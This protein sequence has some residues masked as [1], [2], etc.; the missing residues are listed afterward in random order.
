MQRIKFILVT[1]SSIILLLIGINPIQGQSQTPKIGFAL[2]GGGAKGLAHI[3]VLKVFEEA[4]IYPDVITG[5]SMGSVVGGL[6]AIGYSA[7]ELDSIATSLNWADYF[8][9]T[10]DRSFRTIEDKDEV[11]R[12]VFS[13]P[14][15]GK[16]VQ[17]PRGF[18]DGQKLSILLSNLTQHVHGCPNFDDFETPFRCVGGDLETGE[19]IVFDSGFLPDAIRGSIGIPSVFEPVEI[20]E[21]LVVDGMIIRNLPVQDAFDLGA[22]IVIAVDV[23]SGLYKREQLSSILTVLDQTSSYRIVQSNLQQLELADIVVKPDMSKY[24]ALDFEKTD[25][26]IWEGEKAARHALPEIQK[27]LGNR[28]QN[29]L[30]RKGGIINRLPKKVDLS[31]IEVIGLVGKDERTFLNILQLGEGKSYTPERITE[32]IERVAA[33]GFYNKMSYRLVQEQDSFLLRIRSDKTDNAAIKLGANYHSN[34]NAA[35]LLNATYRNAIL[36]GSKFSLDIRVSE[37]PMLRANYLYYTKSRPNVGVK[38]GGIFNYYPG[39]LYFRN[40]LVGEYNFNMMQVR[41]DFFS[42][43]GLNTSLGF[44]ISAQ[45]H[46][47]SNR[48]ILL[49]DIV[50]PRKNQFITHFNFEFDNLNRKYFPTEGSRLHLSGNLVIEGELLATTNLE[51]RSST[52]GNMYH[53]LSYRKIFPLNSKLSLEWYNH[54][55]FSNYNR[56]DYLQLFY[57]GRSLPYDDKFVPFTGFNYMERPADKYAFTGLRFQ[58]EPYDAIFAALNLNYGYYTSPRFS[59]LR[60]DGYEFYGRDRN[61]MSGVGLQFGALSNFGPISLTSEYNFNTNEVNFLFEMGFGF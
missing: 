48:F 21:R 42:G 43:L 33:T 22:D 59:F 57:L 55:G 11:E 3:G 9:D 1:I 18:V 10:Y 24:S 39:L 56:P 26:L 37:N 40:A 34:Y 16:K 29:Q 50:G 20:D 47:L 13:F 51:S 35:L 45:H 32:Q 15:K 44:G 23:G 52:T 7:T 5:T 41:L 8:T 30:T 25:S 2:S 49:D 6:Y 4:G 53:M 58:L 38:L 27:L 19:A 31:G 17:L 54:G 28:V 14:V 46:S 12:Y 60:T 61:D 36:P